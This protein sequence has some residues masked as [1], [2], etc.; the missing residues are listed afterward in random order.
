LNTITIRLDGIEYSAV[1][2]SDDIRDFL[3]TRLR[4]EW[5][6]YGTQHMSSS[7]EVTEWMMNLKRRRWSLEAVLLQKLSLDPVVLD[8]INP[9][10]GYVF[11]QHLHN[12]VANLRT[13]LTAHHTSIWPITVQRENWLVLDGYCRYT[14]LKE[15]GVP[16]VYA[17][18]GE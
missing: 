3:L 18:V 1:N 10:T 14:T 11:K 7:S 16:R 13:A 6:A 12:R 5:E 9:S 8:F 4:K 2:N 17:Y 15:M